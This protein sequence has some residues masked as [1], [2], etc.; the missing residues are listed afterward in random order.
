MAPGAHSPEPFVCHGTCL[1][2]TASETHL[3]MSPPMTLAPA[4]RCGSWCTQLRT[5]CMSGHM[6][7]TTMTMTMRHQL[8]N[9]AWQPIC[10]WRWHQQQGRGTWRT[11]PR[12]VCITGHMS[13]TQGRSASETRLAMSPSMTLAPAARCGSWRTQLRTVCMSGHM[14]HTTMTRRHQLLNR[15]WQPIC[16]W[17]WHQQ[18]GRST[19]HMHPRTVCI[20]GHMSHTPRRHQLLRRAWR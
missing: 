3:A 8:L 11:Q 13:H 7:H 5:V 9:R 18:Q 19:W 10:Q 20:S 6:S 15:A 1:R 12:T 17:R 2:H 4:A 16:R 14:F